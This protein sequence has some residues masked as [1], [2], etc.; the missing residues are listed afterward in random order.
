MNKKMIQIIII[1]N[2][3]KRKYKFYLNDEEI[4]FQNRAIY[5]FYDDLLLK[6]LL[7]IMTIYLN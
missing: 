6:N 7:K 3:F 2:M 4:N 1:I 5:S